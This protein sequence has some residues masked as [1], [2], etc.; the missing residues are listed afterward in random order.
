M[1]QKQSPK[2]GRY[3]RG[4]PGVLTWPNIGPYG[5]VGLDVVV[6][7]VLIFFISLFLQNFHWKSALA[8]FT[9]PQN[10]RPTAPLRKIN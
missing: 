5:S 2:F 3:R 10:I 1:A 6:L 9:P 8:F 7:S 4:S